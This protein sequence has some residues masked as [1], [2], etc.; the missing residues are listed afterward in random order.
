MKKML[1]LLVFS[2]L[3]LIE[4]FA[5]IM[6]DSAFSKQFNNLI[7]QTNLVTDRTLYLSG[8]TV[9]FSG[10]I[11]IKDAAKCG[12]SNVLYIELIDQEQKSTVKK[13]YSIENGFTSGSFVIP[14]ET[15]SGIYFLRAYTQFNKNQSPETFFVKPLTVINPERPLYNTE[16]REITKPDTVKPVIHTNTYCPVTISGLKTEYSPREVVSLNLEID[17]A[18]LELF[19]HWSLSVVIS[20]THYPNSLP[21][22][23]DKQPGNEAPLQGLFWLPEIREVSVSGII[24]NRKTGL[25]QPNSLVYLSVIGH[26]PQCQITRSKSNGEFIFSLNQVSDT[27]ELVLSPEPDSASVNEI[28]INK[29]FSEEYPKIIIKNSLPDESN[30]KLLTNMFINKQIN[31]ITNPEN[32]PEKQE[33][34]KS[35]LFGTPDLSVV[36]KDYIE[37]STFSEVVKELVPQVAVRKKDDRNI[38]V[39]VSKETNQTIPCK[40]VFLDN[41]LVNDI[42]QILKIPPSKIDRIDVINSTHYLGDFIIDGMVLIYTN[43]NNFGGYKFPKESVFLEYQAISG[44]EKFTSPVY[45]TTENILNRN[46]DFRTLLFWEPKIKFQEG[47]AGIEFYT[48]DQCEDYDIMVTGF[49]KQGNTTERLNS[50]T[51]RRISQ[52]S[53]R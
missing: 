37:L 12:I 6:V 2:K 18:Q 4:I 31:I 25:P 19:T 29:D 43:T 10:C 46:P 14:E 16:I 36:I 42:D 47:K 21:V 52:G 53:Q 50:F 1:F 39:L 49:L 5:Q 15:L 40:N 11:V 7:E 17:S 27:I 41:V 9:W 30:R 22:E 3:F 28:F 35:Y 8:E 26:D 48:S 20:G 24:K 44:S 45:N 32:S 23:Y 38:L 34:Q 33:N 51:V 13:K